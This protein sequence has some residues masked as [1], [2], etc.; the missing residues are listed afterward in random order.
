MAP[1]RHEFRRI[2]I[3]TLGVTSL[4]LAFALTANWISPKGLLLA[5]NYFP[6][7]KK[8]DS[9]SVSGGATNVPGSEHG[10]KPGVTSA[11]EVVSTRLKSKGLRPIDLGEALKLFEDRKAGRG[12][13]VFVDAR[14]DRHYEEGHIPGAFQFDRYYP[15]KHLPS[16]LPACLGAT[17]IVVYCTGGNCEDS[18][19]AALAL[20]D[21][22][23]ASERILV[24]AGGIVEWTSKLLPTE[25]GGRDSGQMRGGNP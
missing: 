16:V 14:D 5:R 11:W 24:Y 21:A 17:K 10:V 12:L 1:K 6:E 13:V 22:G 3:E 2:L 19:F 25:L 9:K 8:I 7:T 23:V 4:G 18:E 20:R 15:E